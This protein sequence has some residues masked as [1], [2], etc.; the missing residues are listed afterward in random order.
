MKISIV[1]LTFNSLRWIEP[2]V[3]AL[4]TTVKIQ[5]REWIVVDN[6]STDG[7]Q[8]LVKTL[9]PQATLI[10]NNFN[11]GVARARNQGIKAST[12]QYVLLLDDDTQVLPYAI[13]KLC[14]YLN[15]HPHCA[16]IAPQLVNPD[17]SLQANALPLPLVRV[18]F[19]CIFGK[20]LGKS[21]QNIYHD[22]IKKQ[23]PFQPGYLLG[24][25]QLIRQEAITTIGPL[26]ERIFYG[27]EDA[28]YCIRLKKKGYEV[29]CLPSVKVIHVYQHKSYWL[30]NPG[31]SWSHLRGLI[32]FWWKHHP[33]SF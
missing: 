4:L 31:L 6:G 16:M 18:K 27:P 15:E 2:C 25:C 10:Q 23:I 17:G 14:E 3:K 30:K 29:V 33:G 28:D 24:A 32:Y 19:K 20:L 8:Q 26:D 5:P 21:I 1:I 12:G 7:S 22:S 11:H 9:L 13:D